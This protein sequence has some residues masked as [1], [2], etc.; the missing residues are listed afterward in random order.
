MISDRVMMPGDP[1][2]PVAAAGP[3]AFARLAAGGMAAPGQG[4]PRLGR[5]TRRAEFLAAAAARR[6][7]VTP[8]LIVQVRRRP[9]PSEAA[10]MLV[11]VGFTASRKVGGAVERNR[12]R[13]RLRA[14]AAAVLPV[15]AAAGLDIVLIARRETLTRPFALLTADIVAGLR[16]LGAL[17]REAA[18]AAGRGP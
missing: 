16:R 9:D 4:A 18:E 11:R 6:K 10:G 17:R 14:A 7:A 8:G 1:T 3:A 5:L 2:E 15:L 12:A 13:R